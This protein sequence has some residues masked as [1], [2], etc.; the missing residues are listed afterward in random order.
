MG[1]NPTRSK[2][3]PSPIRCFP[4]SEL[5]KWTGRNKGFGQCPMVRQRCTLDKPATGVA[6]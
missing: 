2:L 3:R 6:L 4:F 5:K 1:Y